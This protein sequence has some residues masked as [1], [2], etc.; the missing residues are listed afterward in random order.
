MQYLKDRLA[1]K[2]GELPPLVFKKARKPI[3]KKSKK[4]LEAKTGGEIEDVSLVELGEFDTETGE[5]YGADPKQ[6]CS[7]ADLKE[8]FDVKS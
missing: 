5:M 2:N 3:P 4:L 7:L 1:R 6:L 8:K